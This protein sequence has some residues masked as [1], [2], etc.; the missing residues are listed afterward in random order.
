MNNQRSTGARTTG[1]GI[2]CDP[3]AAAVLFKGLGIDFYG[4]GH[5]A[6]ILTGSDERQETLRPQ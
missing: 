3:A 5:S 1:P 2:S 4:A 6:T